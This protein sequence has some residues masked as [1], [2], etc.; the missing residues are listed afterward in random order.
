MEHVTA[1]N[2]MSNRRLVTTK[3]IEKVL[4]SLKKEIDLVNIQGKQE[5]K[6]YHQRIQFLG[7]PSIERIPSNNASFT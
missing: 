1:R 3:D 2:E 4:R 6:P 5:I 7:K